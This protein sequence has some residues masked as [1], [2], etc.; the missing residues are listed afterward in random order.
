MAVSQSSQPKSTGK[1]TKAAKE[2][3][4]N[5][6]SNEPS[7]IQSKHKETD[8]SKD[9]FKSDEGTKTTSEINAA[10]NGGRSSSPGTAANPLTILDDTPVAAEIAGN[11]PNGN[12]QPS[13]APE[14]RQPQA[15]K[16]ASSDQHNIEVI[17]PD[18]VV[19]GGNI[20]VHV[21]SS[22][23]ILDPLPVS[24]T[25]KMV[26]TVAEANKKHANVVTRSLWTFVM[27]GGFIGLFPDHYVK[28]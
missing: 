24:R 18:G 28:I 20:E 8:K 19:H 14:A 25:E 6:R 10:I 22:E 12:L 17:G 26:D 27:I 11:N 16:P 13:T 15:T 23:Q 3:K 1:K 7:P 2:T 4:K 9:E 21:S 5:K